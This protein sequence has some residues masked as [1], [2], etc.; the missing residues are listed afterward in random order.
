MEDIFKDYEKTIKRKHSVNFTPKYKEEFRTSLNHTLFVAIAE[1]AVEKLG[2]DLVF[3]DENSIEA[4]RKEKSLGIERWTE[5]ISAS[6]A[7]GNIVVKSESL[8]NEMWDVGRNSKRVKMFIYS[9]EETLKT[10][11]RQSLNELEKEIKKKNNWDDYVIPE[12][13]PQPTRAKEPNIFIPIIG[14]LVI[15]LILGFVIAF[16]SLKGM[17]FIGLFEFL[18]A[19]AIALTM[20]QLIK[21]SNFTDFNKLQ[22]LL[23]GMIIL[24]YLSNQYFQYEIILNANNYDRIGFLE[25]LKLRF[26][27]GL[28]FN[29]LDTGW[30]GLVIS[31]IL[32]LGLTGLFV[33]LKIVSVLTKY[34]IERVPVEVIDFTYYHFVKDK[35]EGE[36][37]NE[38]AK[39][40]WTDKTNQNE[41]FE[42]IGGFQIAT[43]LNRI[44]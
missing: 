22:Y 20:K 4:K 7:Y 44:K 38:L 2:W 27:Q 19:S 21:L 12:S 26:S 18:V 14:G 40:G 8:G 35:T 29:S 1:K 11:D 15:S 36:I 39:K 31:W 16:I 3:K 41:V 33:Y 17:Y 6:Y 34:A 30:I 42:A 5:A 37:R 28:T 43:E 23:A 13:L 25:F 32:Q 9:F 10:F 24:I